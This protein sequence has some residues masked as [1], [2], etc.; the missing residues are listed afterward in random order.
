[1]QQDNNYKHIRLEYLEEMSDGEV[2]FKTELITDYLEKVPLYI[3]DLEKAVMDEDKEQSVFFAHKLKASFQFMGCDKPAQWT[4]TIE[5][6]YKADS[7]APQ[8]K[9]LL[10]CILQESPLIMDELTIELDSLK[11]E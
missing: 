7:D 4:H 3:S 10:Q 8:M 5:Q 9:Q 2:E 11:Q 1:M 6:T